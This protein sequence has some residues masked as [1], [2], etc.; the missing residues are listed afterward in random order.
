M[1]I[2]DATEINGA[3]RVAQ[4]ADNWGVKVERS[5]WTNSFYKEKHL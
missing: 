5:L 4:S 2:F 1:R 3:Y